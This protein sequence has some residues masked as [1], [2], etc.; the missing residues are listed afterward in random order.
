MTQSEPATPQRV[1]LHTHSNAS[2][3]LYSPTRLVQL[4]HEAGLDLIALVDHDT[5]QGLAEAQEAGARFG[6]T[7]MPG[8]EINTDLVSGGEA[9]ILGYEITPD[10]PSLARNLALLRGARERRG[11]RMVANLRAAGFDISWGEVRDIAKGTVGRPHIAR[12]LIN[13]GYASDVS[14]AFARYLSPGRPGY[15][16]RY[17][18]LPDDA[19]RII[20]SARGI[21]TL[22]HPGGIEDLEERA[23]PHLVGVGLQGLECYYGQY[24]KVTVERL[25]RAAKRFGLVAT[26][27]SDYH[28]PRMHPTPLGGRHVPPAVV[29]RLR[30]ARAAALARPDEPFALPPPPM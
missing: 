3:G 28:G 12:A 15:S 25:L 11:E 14:D 9:H 8:V 17:K 22:A 16:P 29:D 30:A 26:G 21:P 6:V 4:A 27:G 7:V 24:D 23:L 10:D 13:H 20:R 2:D 1:D 19:I 18:L 5:T